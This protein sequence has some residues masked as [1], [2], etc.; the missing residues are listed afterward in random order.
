MVIELALEEL[1]VHRLA[2]STVVAGTGCV[3][4]IAEERRSELVQELV[5]ALVAY[6]ADTGGHAGAA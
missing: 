1:A 2:L 5:A 6:A 3:R 4:G